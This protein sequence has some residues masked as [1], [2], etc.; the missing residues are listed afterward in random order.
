MTIEE[1]KKTVEEQFFHV[2]GDLGD[3]ERWWDINDEPNTW[4]EIYFLGKFIDSKGKKWDIGFQDS[5]EKV[6]VLVYSNQAPCY[7]SPWF[8]DLTDARVQIAR[9]NR[10]SYY[11]AFEEMINRAEAKGL[12]K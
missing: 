1:L 12:I 4:G 8:K 6:G 9:Y 7:F 10:L 11:E 3:V 2:G 5:V